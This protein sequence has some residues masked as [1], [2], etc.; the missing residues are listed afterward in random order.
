[1]G[2]EV[3][4]R[5][6]AVAFFDLGFQKIWRE[7]D[8]AKI[9]DS[10]AVIE[11]VAGLVR[12]RFESRLMTS[13]VLGSP[14]REYVEFDHWSISVSDTLIIGASADI[15]D[16]LRDHIQRMA[17][18]LFINREAVEMLAEVSSAIAGVS[19]LLDAALLLRGAIAVGGCHRENQFVTG[20]VID[21]A[22]EMARFVEGAMI[23][24]APSARDQ[25]QPRTERY[26][27]FLIRN[28]E[29]PGKEGRVLRTHVVSPL[30]YAPPDLVSDRM[31]SCFDSRHLDVNRKRKNTAALLER[32]APLA[33]FGLWRRIFWDS[34]FGDLWGSRNLPALSSMPWAHL[35][36]Y[37]PATYRPSV[38]HRPVRPR[39]RTVR[40]E[41]PRVSRLKHHTPTTGRALRL[42]KRDTR[43]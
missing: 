40:P 10:L 6:T 43:K 31:L 34:T 1:M 28:Y 42:L 29:V 16:T 9:L 4:L 23:I 25:D 17:V 33:S 12:A 19:V 7:S 5:N 18:D 39:K 14:L 38:E 30:S 15:K 13:N 35:L 37:S 21:E 24:F 26:D 20:P 22:A 3:M 36:G 8:S 2:M 11:D 41:N 27:E 32:A